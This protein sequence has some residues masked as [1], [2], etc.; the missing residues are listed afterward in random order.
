M[1]SENKNVDQDLACE[2]EM[3][4]QLFYLKSYEKPETARMTRNKQNIMREVRTASQQRRMSLFDML[5]VNFPWFFAEPK[6]GVALIFVAFAGLQYLGINGRHAA[7][8]DTG[9]YTAAADQFAT[10]QQPVDIAT[11]S[12]AYPEVPSGMRLFQD[13]TGNGDVTWAARW[14][15]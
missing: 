12:V 6:Y 7:Q 9:I 4:K 5:E 3:L 14:E 13:R 10:Y 15:K 11:N 8:S 1:M 2:D